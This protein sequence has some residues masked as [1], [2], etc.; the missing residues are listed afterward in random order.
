MHQQF[1]QIA[2]Q[3]L[4]GPLDLLI[5]MLV[6]LPLPVHLFLLLPHIRLLKLLSDDQVLQFRGLELGP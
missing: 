5:V 3:S 1:L 2:L 6:H 4:I